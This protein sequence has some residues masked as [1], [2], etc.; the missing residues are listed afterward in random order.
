MAVKKL[1]LIRSDNNSQIISNCINTARVFQAGNDYFEVRL[2]PYKA[3]PRN[4][5]QIFFC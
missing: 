1:P 3:T 5:K 4:N 2:L